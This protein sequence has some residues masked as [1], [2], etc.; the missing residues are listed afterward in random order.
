MSYLLGQIFIYLL[1]AGLIGGIIG[2]FLR[3]NCENDEE[4]ANREKEDEIISSNK[5]PLLLQARPEGK[6]NLTLI[7]GV[8]RVLEM[9][10][11]RL[12]V[13][14][15]NQISSWTN[16]QQ[17]WVDKKMGLLGRIEREDWVEQ[18]QN[19]ALGVETEFSQ[20]VKN[21]NVPSSNQR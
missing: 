15:F 3:G 8:G 11:N 16:E 13:Y 7:K 19:L 1:I 18:A 10:L 12:G 21:G 17:V 2:W 20:R 6:D 9:N 14:H 4:E 5:P